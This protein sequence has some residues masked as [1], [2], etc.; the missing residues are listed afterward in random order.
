MTYL[1]RFLTFWYDFLVGDDW[2]IA[3]GV[4]LSLAISGGL[5]QARI[6]AWPSLP[7]LIVCVLAMSLR[8]ALKAPPSPP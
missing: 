7:L 2:S 6:T 8:R 1:I 4:I 5:V 3:V